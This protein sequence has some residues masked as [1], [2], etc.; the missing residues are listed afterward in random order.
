[1]KVLS[2]A[3]GAAA[4]RIGTVVSTWLI[5]KGLPPESVE[6]LMTA[7]IILAGVGFDLA[8]VFAH[9]KGKV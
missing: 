1:M 2:A 7:A 3:L 5:A 4:R 6:Q 9:N 8:M